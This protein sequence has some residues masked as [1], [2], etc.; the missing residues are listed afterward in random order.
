MTTTSMQFGQSAINVVVNEGQLPAKLATD[1]SNNTVLVGADGT[2]Y[3]INPQ[4]AASKLI[5]A[6]SSGQVVPRQIPSANYGKLVTYAGAN[7]FDSSAN[8]SLQDSVTGWSL[9]TVAGVGGIA[10][11]SSDSRTGQRNMLLVQQ[12]GTTTG[13]TVG[14]NSPTLNIPTNGRFGLWV[15]FSPDSTSGTYCSITLTKTAGSYSTYKAFDANS[16]Q[17]APGWNYLQWDDNVSTVP[18]GMS[19]SGT[20]D[21][22]TGSLASFRIAIYCAAGK[23]AKWYFDSMVT[24]HAKQVSRIVMGVDGGGTSDLAI[25]KQLFDERGWKGYLNFNLTGSNDMT[26]LTGYYG[27]GATGSEALIQ[28][29]YDA[30]WDVMNHSLNHNTLSGMATADIK[31]VVNALRSYCIAHGWTRGMEFFSAAQNTTT[32]AQRTLLAGMGYKLIRGYQPL[33]H[34]RTPFGIANPY[35]VGADGFD[36]TALSVLKERALGAINYGAD[37]W[38]AGHN[39]TVGDGGD[40]TGETVPGGDGLHAYDNTIRLFFAW[41]S[42]YVSNGQAVICTPTEWFYGL[43]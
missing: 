2:R 37:Y 38:I 1:A 36:N 10:Y 12:D 18:Y 23:T 17:I 41:L 19:K 34:Y 21:M 33:A 24:G 14:I 20:L 28:A 11:D 39:V 8:F 7:V 9:S 29:C 26:Q 43:N 32:D 16:Y 5:P 6:Y 40:S 25:W 27:Q 30:G 15:Y 35:S 31:Y 42:S 3:P 4:G 22:T 13:G